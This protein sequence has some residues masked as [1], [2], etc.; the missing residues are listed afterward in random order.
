M[1]EKVYD[2][3]HVA[4]YL[5]KSRGDAETDLVKHRDELV[6]MCEQNGWQYVEY[7]EIGTGDSIAARPKMQELLR[8]VQAE[9]YDAVLAIHYDRLGRG[10]K[11]D[12]ATIEKA[13]QQSGTLLV[14]PEKIYDFNDDTDLMLAD[15]LGM[16]ARQEYKA[17]ARRM[18]GGK[19]RGAKMGFWT[20]GIPPFPYR[21]NRDTKKIEPDPEK[22]P[23]YRWMV[24]KALSGYSSTDIAWELN[25][26]GI[27]SPRGGYW[28]PP[29]VRRLLCDEV[30][31]GKIIVG[32][33]TVLPTTGQLVYKPKEEWITI[34]NCHE[35]V[36]TQL[37][38]DK[39][40]FLFS[41][42][43]QIPKASR[44]GKSPFSGLI[45]CAK[46]GSTMQIQKRVGRS[47]SLKA[48]VHTDHWGNRC[49]VI[50][51]S[52]DVVEK[53]VRTAIEAKKAELEEA[54]R[55]GI[56]LE[57][58]RVL[59]EMAEQKLKEIR[60]QEKAIERIYES[61]EKG[62]YDDDDFI[63]R[64][65]KAKAVL[66][67]LEEELELIERQKQNTENARNE[68]MLLSVKEVLEVMDN[69]NI[70][71]KDMNRYYKSIIHNIIWERYDIDEPPTITVNFL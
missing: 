35:P 39:I 29:V 60:E 19:R 66:A 71:P 12:Q 9:M 5:R 65:D 1:G 31:L 32:K 3:R 58:I 4:I 8:D 53:Y 27:P 56:T 57:D 43:T 55:K 2:I 49:G 6:R 44:A 22:L 36:K 26:M 20:N 23:I 38:H 33:K 61:Y 42:Q 41:R 59:V 62:I 68:D 54:I 7:A 37:E 34:H 11:I 47:D 67:K 69:P 13:F 46:C 64:R 28:S 48:C 10:D 15:F 16:I 63:R 17:I 24:E 30:H 18:R 25:K 14:T 40:M 21:Y 45:K 50:G 51:G 52:I 70:D